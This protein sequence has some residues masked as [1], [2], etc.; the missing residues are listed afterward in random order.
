MIID[1]VRF[2]MQ[3]KAKEMKTGLKIIQRKIFALLLFVINLIHSWWVVKSL[4]SRRVAN[5]GYQ[6][7]SA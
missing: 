7:A 2:R 3:I 6:Q 4:L 5:E 1:R